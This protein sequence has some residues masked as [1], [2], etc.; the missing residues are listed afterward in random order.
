MGQLAESWETF[1]TGRFVYHIRQGIHYGLNPALE[2]SRLVNGRELT[3][4]D[5][6]FSLNRLIKTKG[7]YINNASPIMAATT[8]ITALDKYTLEINPLPEW[9]LECQYFMG[10]YAYGDSPK[11]VIEKYGDLRDWKRIV[12]TGPFI[13][14]E[15]VPGS[16]VTF[17]KNPNYYLTDSTGPGKGNKLPYLDGMVHLIIPDMSTELAALR[18]GKCAFVAAPTLTYDDAQSMLKTAP[19]LQHIQDWV[20]SAN[21][22]G[23]RM[24]KKG[25]PYQDIRVRQAMTLAMDYNAIITNMLGGNGKVP[26]WPMVSQAELADWWLPLDKAPAEVQEL[27][28]YNPVK[29]KEL[30]K[31]AGYPNG[32]KATVVVN[33]L[34]SSVDEVSIIK[35]MWQ[36]VGIDLILDVKEDKVYQAI[37]TARNYDDM[38]YGSTG[39]M[40]MWVRGFGNLSS[41]TFGNMSLLDIAGPAYIKEARDALQTA[42]LKGDNAAQA[43]LSRELLAKVLYDSYAITYPQKPTYTFWWPWLKNFYGAMNV[44]AF[45]GPAYEYMWIDQDLKKSMGF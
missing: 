39:T 9:A 3:A 4:S 19:K 13:V 30:L 23:F 11:E 10:F 8:N 14:S 45:R 27:Y 16:S 31:E 17:V 5:I 1:P 42:W 24:D 21:Y 2:A 29:A 38:D 41:N 15:Y 25:M 32:F 18:T 20:N 44:G 22:I 26:A 28:K 40:L 37:Q 34:G 35:D 7:T 43:R 36:K 12:G 33:S 6:A